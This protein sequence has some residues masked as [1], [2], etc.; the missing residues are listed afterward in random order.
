M[1]TSSK[2]LAYEPYQALSVIE[3]A[4]IQL[5]AGYR[6]RISAGTV[7]PDKLAKLAWTDATTLVR[8][9]AEK[10]DEHGIE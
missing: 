4:A 2:K 3:Y 5:A 7:S 8:K 1:T 9:F 10:R 6:A